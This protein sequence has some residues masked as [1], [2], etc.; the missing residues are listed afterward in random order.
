MR[1]AKLYEWQLYEKCQLYK[2]QLYVNF[3]NV[4]YINVNFIHSKLQTNYKSFHIWA[5]NLELERII[6]CNTLDSYKRDHTVLVPM[7]RIVG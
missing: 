4:D 6:N 1:E 7:C 5:L 2:C 3:M